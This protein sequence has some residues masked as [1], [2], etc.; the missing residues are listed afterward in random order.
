MNKISKY[1]ILLFSIQV[2][3]IATL[4]GNRILIDFNVM[5]NN[6]FNDSIIISVMTIIFIKFTIYVIYKDLRLIKL[7][8]KQSAIQKQILEDIEKLNSS[9]RSQRHDFLN[10]IQV[11]YSLVEME[12][13]EEVIKYL[14]EVYGSIELLNTFLKT[15]DIAI[16]ALLRAKSFDAQ[17]KGVSYNLNISSNL[18]NLNIPSLDICRC[19]GNLIDN[20]IFAT[21]E[22]SKEKCVNIC[23]KE[24][25]SAF[26][27]IVTNTGENI[28]REN[29]NK[30]FT[31]GFTTKREFGEGIGLYTIKQISEQYK[32]SI[33][34]VSE[35]FETTFT[36]LFPKNIANN[37]KSDN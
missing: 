3:L 17:R 4:I 10:H 21:S 32:G 5:P 24:N 16:N 36:L 23:I 14:N 9:L 15:E 1:I 22:Y 37:V 35:N 25:I 27:F 31:Y 26:E 28:P 13:Y 34:V 8:N 2:V 6:S 33:N 30:I 12:E 18:H 19:I 11:V 29:L 20:A 7:M